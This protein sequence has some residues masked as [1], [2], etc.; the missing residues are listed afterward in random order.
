MQKLDVWHTLWL[1]ALVVGLVFLAVGF[2]QALA[3]RDVGETANFSSIWGLWVA[4]IG[5]GLTIY[6]MIETQRAARKAQREVQAATVEAQQAI[7]KAASE[8]QEA[9]KNAQEQ[10]R[11]VLERVRHG[12]READFSTLHMWVRELRTAATRGDWH[13]ALLFAEECP[14]VAERLRN[15]AGLEDSERQGLREG[16]DNLRLVQAHIRDTRLNTA[17]MDLAAKHAKSVEALAALLERLGGR[18]HHE[19]TK[20]ATL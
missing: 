16:A 4:L 17:R 8:A 5:F 14:A 7:R 10:T 12:V 9:V 18:L 20:G 6:T 2:R 19:P 15:A 3:Y 11:Q 1:L 13:R